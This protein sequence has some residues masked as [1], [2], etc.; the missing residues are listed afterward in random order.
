MSLKSFRK[1]NARKQGLKIL[2]YGLDGCGKSLI[3]LGF[4][5]VVYID[6]EAKGFV[7]ENNPKYNKNLEFVMD[8]NNYD[9]TTTALKEI[10][11]DE[12]CH[13]IKTIVIDSET[14]IYETMNVVMMELEEERARKKA[15]KHG[16]NVEFAVNDANVSQRAHGK[17]KN[18]HN[19]LK[20]L[21]LQLSSMGVTVIAI[22]HLKDLIDTNTQTKIGEVAD[23]RKGSNYDYDIVIKCCKEKDIMTQKYK[24]IAYIEKDTTETFELGEK[25]D[26]TWTDGQ[27]SNVI[28]EKLKPYIEQDGSIINNYESVETLLENNIQ[29]DKEFKS[30]NL[31]D[32][33]EEFKNLYMKLDEI[34]K[35][36]A[37]ELLN[38]KTKTGKFSEIEDINVFNEI[39]DILKDL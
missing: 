19:S 10:L 8:T 21:K 26:F 24:F 34:G 36:K 4:P 16:N 29:E 28:Y 12:N 14:N 33:E 39:L 27:F 31:E 25:I 6:S 23:L 18:K 9:K 30:I 5:K 15:I 32:K 1:P 7:Y 20:A 38:Q 17:I 35:L 22:A 2:I 11:S 3:T 37:K 13:G